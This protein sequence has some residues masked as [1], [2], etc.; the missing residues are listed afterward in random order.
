MNKLWSTVGKQISRA[1]ESLS[2]MVLQEKT[3][4][5]P[6]KAVNKLI[7]ADEKL[8]GKLEEKGLSGLYLKIK[9]ERIV[10]SG[11]LKKYSQDVGFK[12]TLRPE[13][14]VWTR[15]EQAL[16]FKIMDYDLQTDQNGYLDLV[17]MAMIKMVTAVFR[18]ERV[19]KYMDM[20]IQDDLLKMDLR[21]TDHAGSRV[22]QSVDL[23]QIKCFPGRLS[24]TVQLRPDVARENILQVRD[25]V[26]KRGWK[27][28]K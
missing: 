15:Q 17:K 14:I 18:T 7:Q 22:L 2:D 3:L 4:D 19:L 12:V 10:V 24:L 13:K 25:W 21:D 20:D 6:E 1:R 5:V 8:S 28:G 11:E 23:K 27:T 9:E 16:F 26:K